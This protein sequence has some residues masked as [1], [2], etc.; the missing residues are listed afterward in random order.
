MKA[1]AF[2]DTLK[3][4]RVAVCGIGKNNL[5]VIY[6]LLDYGAVVTACDKRTREQLGDT[7]EALEQAGATLC[8]GEDYLEHLDAELIFRTPGMN[9]NLPELDKARKKGI[10]VTSEMEVFFDLCP[11]TI[12]AVTALFPT[13]VGAVEAGKFAKLL[14]KSSKQT[15]PKQSSSA[16][17]FRSLARTRGKALP[18][19]SQP[20]KVAKQGYA[21]AVWRQALSPTR[22]CKR[23]PNSTFARIF[24]SVCN[25]V[26]TAF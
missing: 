10:A 5:S 8:L 14:R 15:A 1:Q 23:F 4:R 24:T 13:C 25:R 17:T 12:F 26:A 9:W 18:S 3:D 6:Q 19:C 11:A 7:A 20:F 2:L 21:L 16:L 22:C